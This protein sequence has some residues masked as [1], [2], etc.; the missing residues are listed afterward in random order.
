MPRCPRLHGVKATLIFR[1]AARHCNG[2]RDGKQ[3]RT[4]MA[5]CRTPIVLR[6]SALDSRAARTPMPIEPPPRSPLA[7][8]R[9][10]TKIRVLTLGGMYEAPLSTAEADAIL[11]FPALFSVVACWAAPPAWPLGPTVNRSAT[12]LDGSWVRSHL[13]LTHRLL[14]RV[15]SKHGRWQAADR[16][17]DPL[18]TW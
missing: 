17:P 6:L 14:A 11:L 5:R 3:R 10:C 8:M 1:S 4:A 7:F 18:T 12:S 9:R 2:N 13:L 16:V 15:R